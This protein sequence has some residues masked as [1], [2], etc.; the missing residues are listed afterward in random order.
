MTDLLRQL[1]AAYGIQPCYADIAGREVAVADEVLAA[2][3]SR[4]GVP[5]SND[6]AMRTALADS[7]RLPNDRV[8][9]PQGVRCHVPEFLE[10]GRTWGVTCQLYGLRSGRNLGIGDFED[11][12]R[13][14][15]HLASTGA[16]FIGVSPLHALFAAAPDRAS[17]F[18]PSNRQFLNPLLIAVDRVDGHDPGD[19]DAALAAEVRDAELIEYRLVAAV[20]LPALRRAFERSGGVLPTTD[21]AELADRYGDA[22]ARHAL[23]EALSAAHVRSGGSPG[24]HCWPQAYHEAEG[25]EVARFLREHAEEVAFHAW[26]QQQA[27]HQLGDA[28]DRVA[29]A[30][31][32]VG[33]Y[34]DLAVGLAPDGSATWSDQRSTIVGARIG[35]PPDAFNADGQDWGLAP[36]AAGRGF[37]PFEELYEANLRHAGA[38]RLDHAMGLYRL[39]M[40]P[41]GFPA[42]EGTYVLYPLP[43]LLGILA[44]ASQRSKAML[45]GE[46]LGVVPEGFIEAIAAVGVQSYRVMMFEQDADGFRSPADYPRDAFACVATHDTATLAGWWAGTDIGLRATIGL[47]DPEAIDESERQRAS[48]RAALCERIHAEGGPRFDPDARYSTEVAAAVHRLIAA[49]PCRLAAVQLEDLLAS[50]DQP[51]VPGTIDEHPNWRCRAAV[52]V[53]QVLEHPCARAVIEA[54]AAERRRA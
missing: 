31:M 40:I 12:A 15:E 13:L 18:F 8:H 19:V 37:A 6:A 47:L 32:R 22:L 43:E 28:A 36:L 33:L 23:F 51:N 30:G 5:T 29:R 3:L 53:D 44:D 16:D 45:I 54:M 2:L 41:D 9:V 1:A 24:W 39:F 38:L 17:P 14:G 49:T 21:F 4:L 26:L 10:R 20:K 48:E 35:A 42:I 25:P 50:E 27:D 52:G 11:L 7:P 46:A 34:L